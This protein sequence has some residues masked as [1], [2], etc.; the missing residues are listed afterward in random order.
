MVLRRVA[1]VIKQVVDPY[2]C[3]YRYGGDEFVLVMSEMTEDKLRTEV[4]EKI[5]GQLEELHIENKNSDVE[6]FITVTQGYAV[7]KP[8]RTAVPDD[9]FTK[10][11]ACL[12]HGKEKGKNDYEITRID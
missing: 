12:Y 3:V 7:G 4:A 9:Y 1:G 10:A 6:G 5:A 8:Q 11:D 2:G